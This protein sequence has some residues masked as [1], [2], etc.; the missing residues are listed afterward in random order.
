MKRQDIFLS[1]LFFTIGI[2]TRILLLPKMQT[3]IDSSSYSLALIHYSFQQDTPAP[4]GYPLYFG[5]AK[6]FFFITHDPYVALLYVSVL[7]S[8]VGSVVF[9]LIGKSIANKAT[10]VIAALLFLSAPTFYFFGLTAYVYLLVA[11]MTTLVVWCAYEISFKQ[12]K[13]AM[14]FGFLYAISLGVRPQELIT[15]F[16]IFLYGLFSLSYYQ[17]VRALFAFIIFFLLWFLPFLYIVGGIRK[18]IEYSLRA[19]SLALPSPSMTYFLTR[20]FELA[21]GFYLTLGVGTIIIGVFLGKLLL[22]FIQK[23]SFKPKVKKKIVFIIVWI[24]PSILFNFF[25]RSEHAGYQTGY[26]TFFLFL[27]AYAIW[28]LSNKRILYIVGLTAIVIVANLLLFFYD[29]DPGYIYPYRQTSFHYSDLVRNDYVLSSKI[30]FIKNNFIPQKT[31]VISGPIF[32][33]Q[34]RYYFPQYQI[35]EIDALVTADPKFNQTRR[36]AKHW[37]FTEYKTNN[38]SFLVPL[39]IDTIILFDD[40]S[41]DWVHSNKKVKQF[42]GMTKLTIVSVRE[43]GV[44]KYRFHNIQVSSK[45]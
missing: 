4:P 10:G 27:L 14:L 16:P 24:I 9:F 19:A 40:E 42:K 18:Y 8:G 12:K 2:L 6:L 1:I 26:L 35:F 30:N 21:S 15:T 43:G 34:A 5:M 17:R 22:R 37:T 39:G 23:K 13:Y 32:W 3:H 44:V 7:F 25:I 20:K 28:E 45:K 29:R 33:R 36:D 38:Y 11:I 41:N 31:L